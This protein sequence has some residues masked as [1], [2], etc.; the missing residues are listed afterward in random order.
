[1]DHKMDSN[2]DVIDRNLKTFY[3][4]NKHRIYIYMILEI[5]NLQ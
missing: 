1:M 4:G 3:P 5:N 2:D